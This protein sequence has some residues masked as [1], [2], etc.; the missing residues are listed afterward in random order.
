MVPASKTALPL[1]M[2]FEIVES[3]LNINVPGCKVLDPKKLESLYV[4]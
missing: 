3:A 4:I 1:S 2:S